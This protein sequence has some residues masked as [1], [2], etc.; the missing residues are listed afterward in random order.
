M[1][2]KRKLVWS[3]EDISHRIN[4]SVDEVF[5]EIIKLKEEYGSEAIIESGDYQGVVIHFKRLENDSERSR[6]LEANRRYRHQLRMKKI[7]EQISSD[8]VSQK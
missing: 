1:D 8:R 5:E 7:L 3:H 4:G 2:G 6:R